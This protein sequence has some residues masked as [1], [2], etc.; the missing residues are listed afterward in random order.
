[1]ALRSLTNRLAEHAITEPLAG[2]LARAADRLGELRGEKYLYN[3]TSGA[4]AGKES[5][6]AFL[7]DVPEG[8]REAAKILDVDPAVV[9]Q[10]IR[11]R[12][13][14]STPKLTLPDGTVV[15][16]RYVRAVQDMPEGVIPE[17]LPRPLTGGGSRGDSRTTSNT[18][19]ALGLEMTKK[20]L[21]Y[22]LTQEIEGKLVPVLGAKGNWQAVTV[23]KPAK[24]SGFK[25]GQEVPFEAL[26]RDQQRAVIHGTI[27]AMPEGHFGPRGDMTAGDIN[28]STPQMDMIQEVVPLGAVRGTS[29]KFTEKQ[30]A[31]GTVQ[32]VID[33]SGGIV[34]RPEATGRGAYF[35]NRKLMES[36]GLPVKGSVQKV[37][38]LGAA[39]RPYIN[40]MREDGAVFNALMDGYKNDAGEFVQVSLITSK[41]EGIDTA[42][43][44]DFLS[45]GNKIKD[46]QEDGVRVLEGDAR[47][48][49]W[50]TPADVLT[51]GARENELT[52]ERSTA[53]LG[54]KTPNGKKLILNEIANNPTRAE[55]KPLWEENP[56]NPDFLSN[57]D[58]SAVSN[59]QVKQNV[60]GRA[61]TEAEV[62]QRTQQLAEAA[63]ARI[64][65][66][67]QTY[68][69]SNRLAGDVYALKRLMELYKIDPAATHAPAE[70]ARTA[71][72]GTSATSAFASA[73]V[74]VA[75]GT[76][77]GVGVAH[78]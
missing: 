15:R 29:V 61:F 73:A 64:Q 26:S 45:K 50:S 68:G 57:G 67:A 43:L 51:V 4:A 78:K 24:G 2:K 42:K 3:S 25:P 39:S 66:V 14:F 23:L 11:Q 46:Y 40:A 32:R 6:D 63:V 53:A 72:Q 34:L 77:I 55:A 1:M 33:P 44:F 49:F 62:A 74:G 19:Q 60:S 48:E 37:Q 52:V 27:K 16:A 54:A 28:T 22:G 10:L 41:P 21:I 35:T 47:E 20:N 30:L 5:G 12:V 70:A 69:I 31:D 18:V 65:D 38:G 58:G 76:G 71:P 36:V 59:E 8:L 7:A 17:G 9:D 13:I 56:V 75:L